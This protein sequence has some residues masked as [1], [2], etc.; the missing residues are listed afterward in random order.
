MY[1][2]ESEMQQASCTFNTKTSQRMQKLA[3][4]TLPPLGYTSQCGPYSA[5]DMTKTLKKS[6]YKLQLKSRD[7]SSSCSES[8]WFHKKKML[9][10]CQFIPVDPIGLAR[11]KSAVKI[12]MWMLSGNSPAARLASG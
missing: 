5:K 2:F 9:A 11:L 10:L 6:E 4:V 3:V 8:V 7:H 1:P 12:W